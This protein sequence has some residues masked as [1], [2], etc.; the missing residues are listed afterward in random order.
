MEKKRGERM[1]RVIKFRAWDKE[2]EK[3]MP[4][5]DLH[6]NCDGI[7]GLNEY[8]RS[9]KPDYTFMRNPEK[10]VIM[11]HTGLKDDFGREIYEGD[12]VKAKIIIEIPLNDCSMVETDMIEE[13]GVV[14]YNIEEVGYEPFL[15]WNR[16]Y[17]NIEMIEILGNIYE[18]PELLK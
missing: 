12:I 16:K 2:N 15:S 8:K 14:K 17:G 18:N 1:N 4:V 9:D 7:I 10:Y 3:M 6:L 11:Q 13:C 5:N